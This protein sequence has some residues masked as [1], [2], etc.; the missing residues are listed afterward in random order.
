[1]APSVLAYVGA[2][3]NRFVHLAMPAAEVPRRSLPPRIDWLASDVNLAPMVALRY[4]ERFV[5]L[6]R[7]QLMARSRSSQRRRVREAAAARRSD[8]EAGAP[9][10]RYTQLPSH[11]SIVAILAW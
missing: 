6:G 8:L 10:V 4:I 3:G 7:G 11:R 5:A 9:E 2:D 1:M